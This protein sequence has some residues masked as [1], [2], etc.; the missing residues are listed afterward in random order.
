MVP[1]LE[2][3]FELPPEARRVIRAGVATGQTTVMFDDEPGVL[4]EV[5]KGAVLHHRTRLLPEQHRR[6]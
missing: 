2:Q 5:V 3:V 6:S 4:E 1:P